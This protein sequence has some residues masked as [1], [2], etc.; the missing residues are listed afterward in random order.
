MA[1]VQ[2]PNY[3]INVEMCPCK[4]EDCPNRGVC[5]LCVTAHRQRASLTACLRTPRPA[6]TLGLRGSGEPCPRQS[7]TILNCTCTY[8]PCGNRGVCCECLRNHWSSDASGRPACY[9]GM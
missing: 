4:K 1:E 6:A 9:Q 8:E 2:C 5:C 3:T 7:V